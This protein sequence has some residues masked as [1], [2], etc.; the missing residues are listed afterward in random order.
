V[1]SAFLDPLVIHSNILPL[2]SFKQSKAPLWFFFPGNIRLPWFG[3]AFNKF[4]HI[5]T[6]LIN[7]WLI[8][9]YRL[10]TGLRHKGQL[11]QPLLWD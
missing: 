10:G 11:C 8:I 9:T 4:T 1:T 5:W 7:F 6:E 3:V 2:L